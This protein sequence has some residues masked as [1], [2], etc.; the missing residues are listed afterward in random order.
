M[1]VPEPSAHDSFISL[2]GV[3]AGAREDMYALLLRTIRQDYRSEGLWRD[4]RAFLTTATKSTN[5][6]EMA[7]VGLDYAWPS[8][9][10]RRRANSQL[11]SAL[12]SSSS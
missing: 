2:A 10:T 1:S 11:P 3:Y 6:E 12:R 7:C 8:M 4:Q 9:N 5:G